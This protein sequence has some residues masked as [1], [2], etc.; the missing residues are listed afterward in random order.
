M[1]SRSHVF[2]LLEEG[3]EKPSDLDGI[4]YTSLSEDWKSKLFKEQTACGYKLDANDFVP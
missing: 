1:L 3:V 4:V 2:M